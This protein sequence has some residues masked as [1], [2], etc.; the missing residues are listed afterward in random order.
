MFLSFLSSVLII[1]SVFFVEILGFA[2]E[3]NRTDSKENSNENIRNGS[4][5]KADKNN[6]KNK[7]NIEECDN[8]EKTKEC[9]Y[10]PDQ[11]AEVKRY[12]VQGLLKIPTHNKQPHLH[13]T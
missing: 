10:T 3:L 6:D 9:D 7:N 11:L 12:I 13:R 2:E 1:A 4:A 8:E 5:H